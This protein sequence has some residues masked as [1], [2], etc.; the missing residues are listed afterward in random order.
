VGPSP[1]TTTYQRSARR[2]PP[3][4]SYRLIWRISPQKVVNPSRPG[5]RMP[6]FRAAP[7][8][9]LRPRGGGLPQAGPAARRRSAAPATGLG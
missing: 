2:P 8:G 5:K 9:R 4:P 1:H 6:R 3:P 7:S